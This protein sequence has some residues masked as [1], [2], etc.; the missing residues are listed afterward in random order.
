MKKDTSLLLKIATIGFLTLSM[1]VILFPIQRAPKS[2]EVQFV[3]NIRQ[4]EV[5]QTHGAASQWDYLFE[6]TGTT[7][8]GQLSTGTTI[9]NTWNVTTTPVPQTTS[10]SSLLNAM[11]QNFN[12]VVSN[13]PNGLYQG[14]LSTTYT[15]TIAIG[16]ADCMTP[17]GQK[18]AHKDFVLAY[19]QRKDVTTMC[20]VER[21][22]CSNGTLEWSYTQDSCKEDIVYDYTKTPAVSYNEPVINPLVQPGQP[23]NAGWDF[24]TNGQV[25]QVKQPTNMRWSS[26][27][28]NT[29][30][31]SNVEQSTTDK[32]NCSTPRGT[33]VNHGQ[34]VKAYKT[35]IGLLDMPCETQLRLCV[36]GNLKWMFLNK[37]C[38]VKDM[39][40]NDYLANNKD[41]TIPT[42]QDIADSLTSDDTSGVNLFD[43][44]RKL[45]E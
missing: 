34:F 38:I 17:R 11:Q 35:S 8:V 21:R 36:N 25:D 19:E 30:T 1:G 44:I 32:Q 3:R 5:S 18:I 37:A 2:S 12:Q 4:L 31:N 7:Y 6:D 10:T 29:T 41:I 15:G 45:F 42:P 33:T 39:T 24:G 13:T 26:N 16:T 23:S 43:W 22:I 40:Y 27:T 28:T 14:T 20:N 9:A